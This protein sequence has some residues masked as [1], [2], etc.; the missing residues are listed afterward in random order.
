MSFSFSF[1]KITVI[2]HKTLKLNASWLKLVG[3]PDNVDFQIDWVANGRFL[4]DGIETR[5]FSLSQLKAGRLSFEAVG[6]SSDLPEFHIYG[7]IPGEGCGV[8][9]DTSTLV[10]KP[11]NDK[12]VLSSLAVTM[13][14]GGSRALRDMVQLHDEEDEAA[15]TLANAVYTAKTRGGKFFKNGVTVKSF[16]HGEVA[17]GAIVFVHDGGEKTPVISLAVKDSGK[18]VGRITLDTITFKPVNDPISV[19]A[20]RV[21]LK[22]GKAL[23]L[24][25]K[26][27]GLSDPDGDLKDAWITLDLGGNY[28]VTVAGKERAE[29]RFSFAELKSGQVSLTLISLSVAPDLG[30]RVVDAGGDETRSLLPVQF[31][32]SKLPRIAAGA[33]TL[34]LLR[35]GETVLD[36]SFFR[37]GGSLFGKPAASI[38]FKPSAVIGGSFRVVGHDQAT[39]FTLQELREGRVSF[40]HDGHSAAPSFTLGVADAAGKLATKPLVLGALAFA[41]EIAAVEDLPATLALAANDGEGHELHYSVKTQGGKG[42]AVIH[43][44]SLSYVPVPDATG[45]DRL[46]VE[47][48]D[49]QGHVSLQSFIV[50]IASSD[51]TPAVLV[52]GVAKMGGTL[53]AAANVADDAGL[54]PISYVWQDSNGTELGFGASYLLQVADVGRQIQAIASYTDAEGTLRHISSNLS[55]VIPTNRVNSTLFGNQDSPAVATLAG[56]GWVAAWKSSPLEG[57]GSG[58]FLQRFDQGGQAEGGEIFA[59]PVVANDY[60]APGLTPLADG[61]WLLSWKSADETI[62]LQRFDGRGD[63]VGV[64]S[65]YQSYYTELPGIAA[66]ADG[67]WLLTKMTNAGHVILQ[68]FDAQGTASGGEI[69]VDS[70]SLAGQGGPRVKTL[71]DGGWLVLWQFSNQNDSGFA[72]QRF[73]AS[74][75]ALGEETLIPNAMSLYRVAALKDGGWVLVWDASEQDGDDY[76]IFQQRFATDGTKVGAIIQ[77]NSS[78]SGYQNWPEVTALNDGG[79]VV[80]WSSTVAG[81]SNTYLQR[82]DAQGLT[83][84]GEVLVDNPSGNSPVLTALQDGGWLLVYKGWGGQD[85]DLYQRRFSA[86]GQPLGGWGMDHE[87]TVQISGNASPGQILHASA[88]DLDGL[89]TLTWHWLRDGQAIAGAQ[90]ADYTVQEEDLHS[91]LSVQGVM[92]DG[93]DQIDSALSAGVLVSPFGELKETLVNTTVAGLQKAVSVTALA[94]GG[95]LATWQSR[96]QDGDGYGIYQQRYAASGSAVGN[97]VRVN[98]TT[99]ADQSTPAVCAL[100]DGGW[101]LTWQSQGKDGSGDV[102]LQQRYAANGQASGP[103]TQVNDST[104]SSTV[105]SVTALADGGWVI[106]WSNNFGQGVFMRRFDADGGT[107]AETALPRS[108]YHP[109]LCALADGGWLLTWTVWG[110]DGFDMDIYQQRYAA[111]GNATGDATLVNSSRNGFQDAPSVAALAGGGWVVSWASG[112]NGSSQ[113]VQQ[114][115]AADGSALGGETMVNPFGSAPS[116]AGLADGGWALTWQQGDQYGSQS[117]IYLQ[118]YGA[119][120]A[121]IGGERRVNSRIDG[122]HGSPEV[123]ALADGGW[124][125]A[126]ESNQDG[127]GYGIFQKRFAADD[128]QHVPS[129][130]VTISGT[131]AEDQ[132]LRASSDITDADGVGYLQYMWLANGDS[133]ANGTSVTL[134]QSQVGKAITAIAYYLDGR[135]TSESVSSTP[136][137]LVANVDDSPIG[138]LSFASSLSETSVVQSSPLAIPDAGAAVSSSLDVDAPG[139]IMDLEI[140]LNIHH[141]Y[142]GDLKGTLIAPDGT[143]LLLFSGI[144]GAGDGFSGTRFEQTAALSINQGSAPFNGSFRPIADLSLLQ[145]MA[146]SGTWQLELQDSYAGDMGTLESWSL[147][148]ASGELAGTLR[149]GQTLSAV[150]SLRD[151]DGL[152]ELSF[153]WL[154]DGLEFASGAKVLLGEAQL[155]ARIS[156]QAS[157]T[158]AYGHAE[159][160]SSGLSTPVLPPEIVV[161]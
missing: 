129:G 49:V 22:P 71:A 36:D 6:G 39:S 127:Q 97:E 17:S 123:T 103:E 137:A 63:T 28:A 80:T 158:D 41:T 38:L 106:A 50:V 82:Y 89:G 56:G 86:D 1:N 4:L 139:Q 9:S 46:V 93:H 114:R 107:A 27:F 69:Q 136:T 83:L 118:L 76:G 25:V 45:Q 161:V 62:S 124:L 92:L 132:V 35:Q 55:E 75:T 3:A 138:M 43:G 154:S 148:I 16:T 42:S 128:R 110:H 145:G 65:Q 113:V 60:Q 20:S 73:D 47:I 104:Y 133:F 142:D 147:K 23:K 91:V 40:V 115:Y 134:D 2:E 44:H 68:R 119:D 11:V 152:G 96:D 14:E 52:S 26:N 140:G 78:I 72:Q 19:K 120:G 85:E 99:L 53:H 13:S 159:S 7:T 12:P 67:G 32:A 57:G 8:P 141:T 101:L 121:A 117:G 150:N 87:L 130:S 48:R 64:A 29:G 70:V 108:S 155:G 74:G 105:S 58:I 51:E 24:G 122:V 116:V 59:G 54:G 125:V 131:P 79:W 90:G 149:T 111:D 30:L 84:G 153:H 146:A 151:E 15:G 81:S 157:Y 21:T 31:K 66:L 102:V 94:D 77:V 126:W 88:A 109:D 100:V 10:F 95:W 144:G 34:E 33:Q 5:N 135:G 18:L 37:L 160:V 143:R 61:G 112:Q 156:L 98:T